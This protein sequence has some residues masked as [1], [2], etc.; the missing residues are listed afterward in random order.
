MVRIWDTVTGQQRGELAS[1]Q[2]SVEAVAIAPDGTWLATCGEDGTV[3]IWD[4][5]T[6]QIRAVTR[7]DDTLTHCQWSPGGPSLVA[8]GGRGVYLF[9]FRPQNPARRGS[10]PEYP[11]V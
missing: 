11:L 8:A 7:T 9:S 6:G 10:T 2:G 3:R 5:T 1:H 4:A